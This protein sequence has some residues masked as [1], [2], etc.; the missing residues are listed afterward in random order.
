MTVRIWGNATRRLMEL[1]T[2]NCDDSV[3]VVAMSLGNPF[4]VVVAGGASVC[5]H[6]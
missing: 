5:V 2:L 1:G 3:F 6:P 4:L